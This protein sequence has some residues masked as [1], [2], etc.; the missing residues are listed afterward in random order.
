MVKEVRPIDPEAQAEALTQTEVARECQI[1]N[2]IAGSIKKVARRV[3]V[4][5]NARNN[6]IL[7]ERRRIEP[8]GRGGIANA[9]I[10][11]QLRAIVGVAVEVRI[12]VAIRDRKRKATAYL[13]D[14]RDTPT[15]HQMPHETVIAFVVF[16]FVIEAH[17]EDVTLIRISATS[18]FC[19]NAEVLRSTLS[20]I[21]LKLRA[22]VRVA[23][24]IER[25]EAEVVTHAHRAGDLKTVIVSVL[26]GLQQQ[27][28]AERR[29]RPARENVRPSTR[30]GCGQYRIV[31]VARE[32]Q[33]ATE[34]HDIGSA[35]HQIS[36]E[37][38]LDAKIRLP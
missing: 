22:V 10:A 6:F 4:S 2:P 28:C 38:T 37:L 18:I 20:R 5:R 33:V 23:I 36:C 12:D 14:W 24:S 30:R 15:I 17:A 34:R 19:K 26:I 32:R 9:G 21:V 3:P 35:H 8:L 11:Y 25:V 16:R 13:D 7:Q 31:D 1:N 29:V 27:H